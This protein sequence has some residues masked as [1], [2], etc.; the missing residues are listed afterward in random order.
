MFVFSSQDLRKETK[1]MSD[2]QPDNNEDGARLLWELSSNPIDDLDVFL[3][4][5]LGIAVYDDRSLLLEDLLERGFINIPATFQS[6]RADGRFAFIGEAS[7]TPLGRQ[8][9]P[10]H[11][12]PSDANIE[13]GLL[14]E[15]A[16]TSD[17]NVP[18]FL[19]SRFGLS[20]RDQTALL[21][22]L[23]QDRVIEM[24]EMY[25]SKRADGLFNIIDEVS[26]TEQGRRSIG[27]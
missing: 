22:R 27:R 25:Q 20:E 11:P 2:T 21:E 17:L 8:Q 5:D 23:L 3:S 6:K 1:N 14:V 9:V 4:Q 7:I 13:H 12:G 19:R 18:A 24:P 10:N 15:L 16:N 26:I